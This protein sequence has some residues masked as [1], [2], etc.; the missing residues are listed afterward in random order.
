M[1]AKKKGQGTAGRFG[2]RYGRKLREKVSILEA[3]QKAKHTCP[4]CQANKVKRVAKGIWLCTKC[5]NKF[6]GRA[7]TP[8]E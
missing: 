3:K 8:G 6:A 2:T 4:K 7:Y 1:A 5:K